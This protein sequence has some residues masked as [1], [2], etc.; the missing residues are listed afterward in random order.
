MI[1]QPKVD[2]DGEVVEKAKLVIEPTTVLA[3]DERQAQILISKSI[4]D[5]YLDELDRLDVALRP[6]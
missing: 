3:E 4:P 2:K 1:L 5:E 6:F